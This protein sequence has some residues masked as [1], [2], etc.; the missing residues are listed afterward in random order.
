MTPRGYSALDREFP[1]ECWWKES[2]ALVF[3]ERSVITAEVRSGRSKWK[4][5]CSAQFTDT[6][7]WMPKVR[8]LSCQSRGSCWRWRC[9]EGWG[10]RGFLAVRPGPRGHL[11]P[12]CRAQPRDHKQQLQCLLP[13]FP[14]EAVPL[15]AHSHVHP[16]HGCAFRVARQINVDRNTLPMLMAPAASPVSPLAD[17]DEGLSVG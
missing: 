12:S 6:S 1:G 13:G 15:Q 17:Q 8:F 16:R 7:E 3:S 11:A 9:L 5:S 4:I 2:E 10:P 14:R